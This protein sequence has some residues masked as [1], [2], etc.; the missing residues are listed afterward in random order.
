MV[1]YNP[2]I[3]EPPRTPDAQ[4]TTGKPETANTFRNVLE[5]TIESVQF[6]KHASLRMA[7]RDINLSGAQIERVEVGLEQAKKKGIRSSL[8]VVDDIALLVNIPNRTVV[9]AVGKTQ[10]IFTNIDGAVFV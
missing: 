3:Q 1:I 7:A 5:N 10:N 4:K 2:L 8:V 9:T 6:S